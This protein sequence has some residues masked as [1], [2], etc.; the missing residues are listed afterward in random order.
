MPRIALAPV[1]TL[2]CRETRENGMRC[3]IYQVGVNRCGRVRGAPQARL[4]SHATPP[5]PDPAD[6]AGARPMSPCASPC[7]DRN[8]LLS[9]RHARRAHRVERLQDPHDRLHPRS[10]TE[11]PKNV[12]TRRA[13]ATT[14][15]EVT[16]PPTIGASG[17]TRS[18]RAARS[19]TPAQSRFS[20]GLRQVCACRYPNHE[21][22]EELGP[23]VGRH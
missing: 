10:T 6:A 17:A 1:A 2:L 23:G 4:R 22:Y 11:E 14:G 21:P 7:G 18:G 5:T 8:P 12:T 20:T 3:K 15:E 13:I 9:R 19:S 16:W